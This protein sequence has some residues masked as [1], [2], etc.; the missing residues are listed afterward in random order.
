MIT[1]KIDLEY[2]IFGSVFRSGKSDCVESSNMREM[3][4]TP[5]REALGVEEPLI[6]EPHESPQTNYSPNLKLLA[7]EYCLFQF[8]SVVP[9]A[10]QK[11]GHKF[12][13]EAPEIFLLCP[14]FFVV[15]PITGHYRKVQG[16][17]T[18]TELGQSLP[19]VRGR[20]LTFQSRCVKGDLAS[21]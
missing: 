6:S 18:R 4:Y 2:G 12:R 5:V 20:S 13:R 1:H 16:T 14:N 3:K 15:P 10:F 11:W 9:E 7:Y 8:L 17:V 21:R 19:T